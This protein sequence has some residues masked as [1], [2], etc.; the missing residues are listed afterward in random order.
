MVRTGYAWVIFIYDGWEG[1]YPQAVCLTDKEARETM[2]AIQSNAPRA[3]LVCERVLLNPVAVHAPEGMQLWKVWLN[4]SD[5]NSEATPVD[6]GDV[7]YDELNSSNV[8]DQ[9][10]IG[11]GKFGD[12]R[13]HALNK[14]DAIKEARRFEAAEVWLESDE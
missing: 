1:Y 5:E 9:L 4:K 10:C 13:V 2:E 7:F 12:I 11:R 3:D 6:A 8:F 14:D